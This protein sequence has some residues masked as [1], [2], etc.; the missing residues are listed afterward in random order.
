MNDIGVVKMLIFEYLL[1]LLIGGILIVGLLIVLFVLDWKM[2]VLFLMVI[3]LFVL[4]LV[5]FG[6][7]MYKILKVF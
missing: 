2:I 3:L 4:I 1:N 7:K 6:W 5:L